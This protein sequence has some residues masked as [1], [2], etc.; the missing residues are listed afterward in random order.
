MS[1]PVRI[2]SVIGFA[3]LALL[4]GSVGA[5]AQMAAPAGVPAAP[6]AGGSDIIKIRKMT[7]VKEKTPVFRTAVA[8][9]ASAKQPDWWHVVVEFETAPDWIDELEFTYYAYI[10]DQS[11]KGVPVMYRGTVTY[12]NVARGRHLSDMFLHPNTIARMGLVKQIAVVVKAKGAVVATESTA[13]RPN[14]WDGFP[15]VDGVLLNRSQTP[16]AFVDYDLY[17]AIKPAGAAR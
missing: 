1:R 6:G 2:P 5:P 12:V 11:N 13:Q 10:E 14:W 9:Q 7:P 15:P 4:V 17:E 16:F 8:S 3:L